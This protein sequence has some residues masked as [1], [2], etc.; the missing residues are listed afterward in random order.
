ME[1]FFGIAFWSGFVRYVLR[2]AV[3][4]QGFG[5]YASRDSV[6]VRFR[7]VRFGEMRFGLKVRWVRFSGLYLRSIF[8]SH[9]LR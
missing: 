3:L 5:G 7:E 2:E 1:A 6:L 9:R 4:G 8:R